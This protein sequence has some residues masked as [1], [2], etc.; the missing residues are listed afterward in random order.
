MSTVLDNAQFEQLVEEVKAKLLEQSQGVGDVEVVDSL[1]GINSLP[2]LK[3]GN[4]VVEAP[5]SLLSA[6][7][8]E[9][10]EKAYEAIENAED[11]ASHPTYIGEDNYVYVWNKS[12][13]TY[14]K[15]NVYV[16]GEGFKISKTYDSIAAMEADTAHGLK[17]GDFVLINTND[18]ENPD[19]AKIYVVDAQGEFQFLVD[20]SGAIGFTGKTPQ[21]SIGI[22]TTGVGRD[23]A[24][25]TLTDDGFDDEGNPKYK[26]NIK[27]PSIRLS[28]LDEIEIA[29]LQQPATDMIAE[30]EQTNSDIQEAEKGR[31]TSENTRKANEDTRVL[32]ETA[33]QENEQERKDNEDARISNENARV[34]AENTRSTNESNREAS[35]SD[36][37]EA[38]TSRSDAEKERQTNENTRKSNESTRQS[39][40]STR[41]SNESTRK[42]NETT[43][44]ENEETRVSQEGVRENNETLRKSSEST[45]QTNENARVVA[46]QNR[47]KAE[48]TR[49]SNESTRQEQETAREQVKTEMVALNQELKNNPPRVNSEGNWEVWDASNKAYFDTGKTA[50]GKTPIIQNGNWFI[51]NDDTDSYEDTGISVSSDYVLKREN[52][53]SVLGGNPMFYVEEWNHV[54]AP[55]RSGS[56]VKFNQEFFCSLRDTDVPPV[57]LLLLGDGVIAK[58]DEHTYATVGSFDAEGNKDDWRKIPYDELR[59]IS[60]E[61]TLD[62]SPVDVR[63]LSGDDVYR[64]QPNLAID[65]VKG[66]IKGKKVVLTLPKEN[67]TDALGYTPATSEEVSKI[68]IENQYQEKRLNALDQTI[69]SAIGTLPATFT[70]EASSDPAFEVTNQDAAK[71]YISNM[72]GYL[73]YNGNTDG[74]VYAAKLNH[75]TWDKFADGTPVTA[76][77]EAKTETMVHV[78]DCHFKASE[79]T[80]NFG[81][82]VPVAGGHTFGSPHW[83]G[84]YLGHIADGALHSRPNVAPSHSQTMSAFWNYAQ[85]THAN[86][87]YGLANYQFHCLINALYQ[88][89]YG[90][91]NSQEVIGTG[92]QSSSMEAARDVPMGLTK[93][94]GDGTGKVYYNNSTLGDQYPV[95]LFGLE[96]LWGKMWQ[97]CLNIRFET[98]D[99]VRYAIVYDGNQ[100][101]NTA[102]GREFVTTVQNSNG[103][104]VKSMK[105]GEYWDIIS[106]SVDG[107][108]TTYY[109]DGYWDSANGELLRVG[110]SCSFGSRCG[111]SS[112][113]SYD[114]FSGAETQIGAR[115][116][117]WGE[118]IIVS[119]AQLVAMMGL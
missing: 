119:G 97:F 115:L 18:V 79:K 60:R 93:N 10:A 117:Y 26:L 58:L 69:S 82:V 29:M 6:P 34:S 49:Q 1:E 114:G 111:L 66:T 101:S 37:V 73:F 35:E 40:E 102:T 19:N 71:L 38:E 32:N 59:L 113:V 12:N 89:R 90:N 3:N 65:F 85:A 44:Q 2:S 20:M 84:A 63:N 67:V 86:K 8:I 48:S 81:G 103:E 7:A 14:D 57:S 106:E 72:G 56:V 78:P 52:V 62:G 33:R 99:G 75:L 104:Y 9:A 55:Y 39:N 88:A 54:N 68:K 5:L 98:R 22:I 64:F 61:G 91:L 11:T 95:K 70:L 47:A 94:L 28:D 21:I 16:R 41:Q 17:E 76:A 53:E 46:E 83:V 110:G 13:Q 42:T 27:I 31:V 45:R 112:M 87:E 24:S 50:L 36:R 108:E 25:A 96:D 77:I 80:M 23:D 100:V 74:K 107:S 109:C 4:R 116:A 51:W 92:W 43:R 30:L 105:L 15:T 118:P